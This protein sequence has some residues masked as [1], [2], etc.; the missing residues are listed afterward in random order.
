MLLKRLELHGLKSFADKITLD[1]GH[2]VTAIVGPN[3]SG[4]SNITD[5]VRWLLGERD[6]RNLRGAK[7]EDLI[8]A[9]TE[10]RPRM[11]M[12]QATL[13]FDNSSGFFPVDFKEVS[14]SRKI[15]RDGVSQFYINKSEVRL[16]DLIDFLA[17]AKLGAR[18]MAIVNQG[19]SDAFIVASPQERREMIEEILGLKEYQLKKA[20]AIRK[21]K[22]TG[23]NLEK[24]NALIEELKPHLRLLRRQSSRYENRERIADELMGLENNFYGSRL[25]RF[26]KEQAELEILEREVNEEIKSVEPAYKKAESEFQKINQGEPQTREDLKT[27]HTRRQEILGSRAELQRKLGRVEAE[28]EFRS[29]D[30][31]KENA[32][33]ESALKEVKRLVSTLLKEGSAE[34]LRRGLKNVLAIIERVFEPQGEADETGDIEKL[35]KSLA[36]QISVIDNELKDLEG[37]EGEYQK[38]LEGF[39]KTFR[40]AYERVDIEKKKLDDLVSRKNKID[41]SKE[42]IDLQLRS[43]KEELGQ[44]GRSLS[45]LEEAVKKGI[46]GDVSEEDESE[47]MKRMFRLRQELASIGEVDENIVKEARETEE[48]HEFLTVQI[49]DMEKAIKDLKS[50]IQDLD[51]KIYTEFNAAIKSINDEF[52]RIVRELF[53]GGRAKLIVRNIKPV[54][55]NNSE[56][57]DEA[58]AAE[59]GSP[60]ASGEAFRE[61]EVDKTDLFGV[62]IDITLPRKKIRGLD[63]LS[64]GER[65][66]VSIAALF[67]LISISPPP[68]LLLDEIDAA[69]DEK[70]ARRYSEILKE[71]SKKTQFILVT[72]N[73]ATMEV[74]DVL[75]GCTMSG[76]GTSKLVSLKLK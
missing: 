36:S 76:D 14:I 69:L 45:S 51:T 55:V 35:Q 37:Q 28:L 48:R 57:G 31:V 68:F 66:L 23:F 11:G 5:G 32:D 9:G 34:E 18:G 46:V 52:Q 16:R 42:R 41:L 39:N 71:F 63:V 38:L 43:L 22:N 65:S 49:K 7:G 8:F 50:L 6:A 75:Y 53:G 59:G 47:T 3:G 54:S 33:L 56:E 73:R 2:S 17:R 61:E 4:K 74:A 25:V 12:A 13:Y 21:L 72:H 29:E 70:N 1:L 26:R 67:A 60:D 10:K 44:I 40:E 27:V 30:K 62:D 20:D 64:G 19:E 58:K 24:A 15:S